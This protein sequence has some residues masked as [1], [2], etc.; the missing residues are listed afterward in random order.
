MI[1]RTKDYSL[2]KGTHHNPISLQN[3]KFRPESVFINKTLHFNNKLA[4]A[5]AN[6][7]ASDGRSFLDTSY[8]GR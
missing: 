3:G 5:F 8:S 1:I 4:L 6:I 2:H 7:S